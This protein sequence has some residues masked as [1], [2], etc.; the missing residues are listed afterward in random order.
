MTV[1]FARLRRLARPRLTELSTIGLLVASG[2]L[3]LGAALAEIGPLVAAATVVG[4]GAGVALRLAP[5]TISRPLSLISAGVP[6]RRLARSVPVV[7]FAALTAPRTTTVVVAAAAFTL[8]ALGVAAEAG[9]FVLRGAAD[10]TPV[11]RNLPDAPRLRGNG[12]NARVTALWAGTVELAVLL[13]VVCG[14]PP[15]AVVA[16]AAA[17]VAGGVLLVAYLARAV[18]TSTGTASRARLDEV[19]AAVDA[20]APTVLL[21]FSGDAA[22]TYQANMWLPVLERLDERTLVILRDHA[23]FDALAPTRLAVVC[24]PDAQD[25][26]TL[27]L[28]TA[29]VALFPTNVANNIHV[30]RLPHVLS[31]FIG[32]G[33]SDKNASYNPYSRVYDEIWVAGPAGRARYHAA[34]VGVRDDDVVEVGR[35]QLDRLLS[36]ALPARSRTVGERTLLY[37][38]TWEG[39]DAKQ[40]HA[41]QPTVGL[42]LVRALLAHRGVRLI[43]RPHP[44]TGRRSPAVRH[45]D[46]LIRELIRKD[47][48]RRATDG[49]QPH[50]VVLPDGRPLH[51]CF[52]DADALVTDVSSVLSDFLA[53]GRP[54]A[55]TNPGGDAEAAF[56]RKFPAAQ[57]GIL[58]GPDGTGIARF[59][60]V[61]TEEADDELA[62]VREALQRDVLGDPSVPGQVR[63]QAA[64][65]SLAHR[66]ETRLSVSPAV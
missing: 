40:D 46:A 21:V 9:R 1:A 20:Y 29:R 65:T 45:A 33:D 24:V 6:T 43:Y 63:F 35:P 47:S 14:A 19:A 2:L 12:E 10:R 64:V 31:A 57:A 39:W 55:V 62:A 25:L 58:L 3:A 15:A 16:L 8:V 49:R 32:H 34:R 5:E 13:P 60:A 38:P 52:V 50:E 28:P 66:A 37:A 42:A 41:S 56:L 30:L 18:R 7:L 4:V 59:L 61:L 26:M 48:A 27:Q 17:G 22:A 11:S 51:E 54:Y 36:R 44:F 23:V 53:T